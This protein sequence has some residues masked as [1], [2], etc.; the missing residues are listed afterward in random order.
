MCKISSAGHSLAIRS[1]HGIK[2]SSF[3]VILAALW[4]PDSK[5]PGV[6]VIEVSDIVFLLLLC[7]GFLLLSSIWVS[8]Q[9]TLSSNG[10]G[11]VCLIGL[12]IAIRVVNTCFRSSPV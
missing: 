8:Y 2:F 3:Y 5:M 12:L 9:K 10:N 4:M 11:S 7:K 6:C 1:G